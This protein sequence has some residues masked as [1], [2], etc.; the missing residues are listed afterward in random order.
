METKQVEEHEVIPLVI[1]TLRTG[2]EG[3][4]MELEV[5]EIGKL[6]HC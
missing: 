4:E 1:G 3:L 2:Q 5:F 6:Q